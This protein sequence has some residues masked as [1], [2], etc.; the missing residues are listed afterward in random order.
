M[1]IDKSSKEAKLINDLEAIQQK[2]SEQTL[3]LSRQDQ[4][5]PA[6]RGELNKALY[7]VSEA[8][9]QIETAFDNYFC[10]K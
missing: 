6:T 2:F 3:F 1:K 8:L 9:S 10:E 7:S 4:E 5:A